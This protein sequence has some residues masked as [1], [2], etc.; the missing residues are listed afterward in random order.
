[1]AAAALKVIKEAVPSFQTDLHN[2]TNDDREPCFDDHTIACAQMISEQLQAGFGNSRVNIATWNMHIKEEHL[3]SE[4]LASGYVLMGRGG[5]FRVVVFVGEGSLKN[6]GASGFES[7][8]CSGNH[9]VDGNAIFFDSVVQSRSI[10][11]G[12][13]DCPKTQVDLSQFRVLNIACPTNPQDKDW[14]DR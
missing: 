9:R 11:V 3:F 10:R 1:M 2:L 8:F 5:W 4:V 12:S 13:S 14:N 6:N 7:I